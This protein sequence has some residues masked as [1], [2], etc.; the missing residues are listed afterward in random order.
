M[1]SG[2]FYMGVWEDDGEEHWVRM[3]VS[4]GAVEQV[5]GGEQVWEFG[6]V[7]LHGRSIR[8]AFLE[9]RDRLWPE[10]EEWRLMGLYVSTRG[11]DDVTSGVAGKNGI[12]SNLVAQVALEYVTRVARFAEA[13]DLTEHV[14]NATVHITAAERTAWNGKAD[15]ADLAS[16]VGDKVAHVTAAERAVWDGKVSVATLNA[17]VGDEVAHVTAAERA[18]WDGNAG[19][20]TEH[21]GDGQIHLT[22]GEKTKVG[23]IITTPMVLGASETNAD[24]VWLYTNGKSITQSAGTTNVNIIGGSSTTYTSNQNNGNIILGN[25]SSLV[26]QNAAGSF[27]L[28][29]VTILGN[30]GKLH[31]KPHT[32]GWSAVIRGTHL[33]GYGAE[34][35][36]STADNK[37]QTA[38]GNEAALYSQGVITLGM[39]SRFV[40]PHQQGGVII[41]GQGAVV[42]LTNNRGV[43]I[44]ASYSASATHATFGTLT[45]S[46]AGTGI[47]IFGGATSLIQTST[48]SGTPTQVKGY[49]KFLAGSGVVDKNGAAVVTDGVWQGA[50]HAA[51]AVKHITAAERTAWNGKAAASDLTSHTGNGTVHITAA[52]R[53]TW[54]G[55]IGCSVGGVKDVKYYA[56]ASAA[57]ALSARTAGVLYLIGE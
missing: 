6:P 12:R 13:G 56:S 49:M 17:H 24:S 36:A 53:T 5:P 11:V 35:I 33:F 45:H 38:N 30:A 41:A 1:A 57:P 47:A 26:S 16:H 40:T 46:I 29:G 7:E 9:G 22:A 18:R 43:V 54:N 28:S 10:E 19:A 21:V 20:L 50:V 34:L 4:V 32:A 27:W 42:N 37:L 23:S 51:D 25:N 2:G 8:L 44:G 3:G 52:E 15:A 55:K 48:V 31:S 14:G 39:N